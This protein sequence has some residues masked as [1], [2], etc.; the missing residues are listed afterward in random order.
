[1][2]TQRPSVAAEFAQC[3]LRRPKM[4][5][6]ACRV[7]VWLAGIADLTSSRSVEAF[8]IDIQK[9]WERNGVRVAGVSFR[10]ETVKKSIEYLVSEGLLS[11]TDGNESRGSSSSNIYTFL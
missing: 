6:A 1:M 4:Q 9:G 10:H 2:R 5:H 11:V 7:G 3:V 8:A